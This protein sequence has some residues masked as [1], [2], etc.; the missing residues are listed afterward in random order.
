MTSN[1][2]RSTDPATSHLA[3]EKVE[4]M[5][6]TS[7]ERVLWVARQMYDFADY[8]LIDMFA[9]L[10]YR[11]KVRSTSPSRIRTARSE[12]VREGLIQWAGK[13]RETPLGNDAMVWRA[14]R[15]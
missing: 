12:L 10:A 6:G 13:T 2:A 7:K 3:A 1:L 9:S 14:V 15:Q 4:P 5:V 11:G 8:E